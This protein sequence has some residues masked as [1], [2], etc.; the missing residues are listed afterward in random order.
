MAENQLY[1]SAL[2][3]AMALCSRREYC[4]DDISNKL[5]SWKVSESDSDQII[6]ALTKE[7]FINEKRYAEAFVKDKFKYY[8]WGKVKIRANLKMKK[9]PGDMINSAL[10]LIDEDLYR[11]TIKDLLVIHRRSVKAKN[12]Y[13]LKGKLLRYGLS[14]GFESDLL[15][16]I[17][18]DKE[19]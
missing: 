14:K 3:K 15:Y 18:S 10:N 17:I 2:S 19:Q 7:N 1:K 4:T 13:D 16:E 6:A 8:R 12:Q 9:I 11:K 5:Q